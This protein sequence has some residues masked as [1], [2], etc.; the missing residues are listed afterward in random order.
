MLYYTAQQAENITLFN[1]SAHWLDPLILG[2]RGTAP[3]DG[4]DV[5]LEKDTDDCASMH[6]LRCSSSPRYTSPELALGLN[7]RTQRC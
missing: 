6:F 5:A 1:S 3:L 2:S 4:N 7:G